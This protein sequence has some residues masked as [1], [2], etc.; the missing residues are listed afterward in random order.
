MDIRKALGPD[1]EEIT[2][3]LKYT[4]GIVKYVG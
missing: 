1:G 3:V 4:S 2:P